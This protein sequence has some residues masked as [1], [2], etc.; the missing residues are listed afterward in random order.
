MNSPHP[1]LLGSLKTMLGCYYR[2]GMMH[3]TLLFNEVHAK[4]SAITRVEYVDLPGDALPGL[5]GGE[6]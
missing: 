4:D 3:Q 6:F 2:C 1:Q 5:N